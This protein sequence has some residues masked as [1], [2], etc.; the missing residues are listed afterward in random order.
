MYEGT[1]LPVSA[2]TGWAALGTSC[3]PKVAR[4]YNN[5][6]S[7]HLARAVAVDQSRHFLSVLAEE[8]HTPPPGPLSLRSTRA[9]RITVRAT[10]NARGITDLFLSA[11]APPRT[12]TTI[13]TTTTT[14]TTTTRGKAIVVHASY[15]IQQTTG[16]NAEIVSD[17]APSVRHLDRSRSKSCGAVRS[18]ATTPSLAPRLRRGRARIMTLASTSSSAH[19]TVDSNKDAPNA[20]RRD[21]TSWW[22]RFNMRMRREEEKGRRAPIWLFPFRPNRV[23]LFLSPSESGVERVCCP[24]GPLSWRRPGCAVHV[25]RQY[26]PLERIRQSTI[27]DSAMCASCIPS[28]RRSGRRGRRGRRGPTGTVALEIGDRLVVFRLLPASDC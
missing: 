8:L 26:R 4:P 14:T 20:T 19:Q 22:K 12:T 21:L 13:I 7:R 1:Y 16:P 15:C 17:R 5:N 6:Y 24:M 9:V 11:H 18:T 27:C 25:A 3:P 2:R 23:D 28:A 10:S